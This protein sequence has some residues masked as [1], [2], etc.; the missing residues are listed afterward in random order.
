MTQLE[1]VSP[2]GVSAQLEGG[3]P[4]PLRAELSADALETIEFSAVLE[5]VAGYAVGPLGA[6]RCEP[7]VPPPSFPG[8]VWT[9]PGR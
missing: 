3:T 1:S 5:R 7:G 2:T 8:S 4:L 6:A 9:R